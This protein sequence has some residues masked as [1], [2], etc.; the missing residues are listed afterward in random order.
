TTDAEKK[1]VKQSVETAKSSA[2]EMNA[3]FDTYVYYYYGVSGEDEFRETISLNYKRSLWIEDYAKEIVSDKQI[4]EYYENEVVGDME[5]SHIL[6]TSKAAEGASDDDKSKAET[7]AYQEAKSIIEKLKKGEDFATLAKKYSEDESTSKNGGSLGK[8]NDGDYAKEVIE[9]LKT[10][11]VGDYTLIPVKSSYGYH[12][13][14]KSS[15]DDK[16]NL[17]DTLKEEITNIIS[18]EIA[19]ENSFY[20]KALKALREKNNMKILDS[21]L[22]KAYEKLVAQYEAQSNTSK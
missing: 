3:D 2:K 20:I 22:E 11:K 21:E 10:L 5:A 7:N 13:I 9:S 12:I 6:I 18:K 17:D 1:Y 8:V 14:Y 19:S 16:P 4:K 15:Q